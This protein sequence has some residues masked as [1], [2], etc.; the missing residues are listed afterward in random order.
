M[1]AKDF[2]R[3]RALASPIVRLHGDATPEQVAALMVVLTSVAGSVEA[4]EPA[5][6][7]TFL[8]AGRARPARGPL[9]HGAGG[10]RHS[11]L[12]R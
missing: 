2:R 9:A 4:N 8:W 10:W 5:P 11:A 1:T 7:R 6:R 3:D 12:P